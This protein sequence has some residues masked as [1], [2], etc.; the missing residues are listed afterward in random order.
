MGIEFVF[1]RVSPSRAERGKQKHR[2]REERSRKQSI[3][4]WLLRTRKG[5]VDRGCCFDAS[6]MSNNCF[7]ILTVTQVLDTGTWTAGQSYK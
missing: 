1:S 3:V 6:L 5:V 4:V 7:P 2:V